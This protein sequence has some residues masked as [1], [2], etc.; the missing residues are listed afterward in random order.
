MDPIL[1][2]L[3]PMIASIVFAVAAACGR[4]A[5]AKRNIAADEAAL[6]VHGGPS[7]RL[8]TVTPPAEPTSPLGRL[9]ADPRT[10]YVAIV[11]MGVTT[12]AWAV[13]I[14]SSL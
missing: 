12:A 9:F 7:F 8:H 4:I 11:T 10:L 5:T 14:A 13:V 3:I 1:A 6:T 2:T